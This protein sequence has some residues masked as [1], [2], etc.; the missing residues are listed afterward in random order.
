MS[1][2]AAR[3]VTTVA[4][5]MV[6]SLVAQEPAEYDI[7]TVVGTGAPG[8]N[9][10][11]LPGP[12]TRTRPAREIAVGPDGSVYFSDEDNARLRRLR[13]DGT[14]ETIAGTGVEAYSGD[15]GPA[16][17]ADI[18][19]ARGLEVLDDGTIIFADAW[20]HVLRRIGPDGTI[21][22]ICG[23]GV[24]G[25]NGDGLPALETEIER[26]ND[27]AVGPDGLVY[28]TDGRNH[29]IRR[30]GADGLVT[31]LAGTGEETY[32]GDGGPAIEARLDSPSGID[33]GPDGALYVAD[34]DN[35]RV[36]RIVGGTIETVVGRGEAEA[37]L[38]DVPPLEA[39]LSGPRDL[40][41]GPDGTLYIADTDNHR[42]AMVRP[43]GHF[44][45]LA[46]SGAAGY[47][48]DGGPAP[49]ALLDAPKGITVGADGTVYVGDT[50]NW[51]IRAIAPRLVGERFRRGDSDVDGR[52]TIGDAVGVLH[53]LFI[54]P[55]ELPCED[56]ADANDDGTL[57]ITDP[58]L[59]LRF[60]FLGDVPPAAPYPDCGPDPADDELDCAIGNACG[61]EG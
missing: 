12:Q 13:L 35:H 8:F 2:L 18:S 31:T 49:L 37:G 40:A 3:W 43:G 30:I 53:A 39:S 20:N 36:R 59:V 15:G 9:G 48:G 34:E 22:T 52:L 56:A 32:G 29:R 4:L 51:V 61:P 27:V 26:P 7:A 17:D 24:A 46:G 45:V 25:F 58:V 50:G 16:V 33:F 14:V 11:G 38:D 23:T 6:A 1:Q 60:L 21:E 5:T 42:V 19:R 28:F 41:F 55:D 54:L 57:N 47:V 44:R 10:D